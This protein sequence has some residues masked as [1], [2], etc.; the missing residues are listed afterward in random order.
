MDL[1]ALRQ[2]DL[3]QLS[4]EQVTR[5]W[6]EVEENPNL[7][8]M[9]PWQYDPDTASRIDPD[10]KGIIRGSS[11]KTDSRGT[12]EVLQELCFQKATRNPQLNTNVRGQQGRVTGLGFKST[13]RI[14][15]IREA[16]NEIERDPRNRLYLFLP[17]YFARATI[18]GELF[19]VLTLHEDG[20]VEVDFI[21]PVSIGG[22]DTSDGILMHPTKTR[23]PLFY[24][25]KDDSGDPSEQ[26][27]SIFIARY[28]E[29]LS[30]A[31]RLDGFD[32]GA[33]SKKNGSTFK[34]LKGY[35]RFVVEWDKTWLTNR[36]IAHLRTTIGWINLW[37]MM[38]AYE[39]DHKKS[40]G[41][42]VWSVTI[43]DMRTW[44]K[45]LALSDEDRRKTG[46]VDKKTPGS[47]LI[48]GPNMTLTAHTLNLP[49]ISD[50]DTDI[51]KM[52][53]AGLNETAD[54]SMGELQSTFASAKAAKGP[55]SD[56]IQDEIALFQN[57]L[58]YDF[59]G[60]VFFLKSIVSNFPKTFPIKE[61][62]DFKNQEPVFKK[63]ERK[64]EELI[65]IVW[66]TSEVVDFEGRARG[67]LGVKHGN[68]NM[69]LGVSNTT[70]CNKLGFNYWTERLKDATEKEDLPE[71]KLPDD[72]ESY[73][74]QAEG[75][76]QKPNNKP[77][78][79]GDK[80]EDNGKD[81]EEGDSD[82]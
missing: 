49:R 12:R 54:T 51:Q 26:I 24:T 38:K 50:S 30:E 13:S 64:P 62:V 18:E 58:I 6:S 68:V 25:I 80:K 16:I 20:F 69:S 21:D 81:K 52:I 31:K 56:R 47:T 37:E 65:E 7:L 14:F 39:I 9:F 57:F 10:Q 77:G 34:L 46:I 1:T 29:M 74:E 33:Q 5:L 36:N 66:P 48:L 19:L 28:P 42:Y 78:K 55:A 71:L 15:E 35:H 44:L 11:D 23:M 4:D 41:A 27:P 61:A 70:I 79:K 67:L 53:L 43:N 76:P 72:D 63:V 22:T 32:R 2:L 40:S 8:S 59:W 73:Q 75:E 3:D 60:S 82:E 45:W 17:K